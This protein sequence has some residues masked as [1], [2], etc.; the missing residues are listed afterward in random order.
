MQ[1]TAQK[2][3]QVEVFSCLEF[4]TLQLGLPRESQLGKYLRAGLVSVCMW[5]FAGREKETVAANE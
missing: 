4:R 3:G 5:L 1:L 2:V